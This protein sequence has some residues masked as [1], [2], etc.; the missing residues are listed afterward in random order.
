MANFGLSLSPQSGIF[1]VMYFYCFLVSDPS[2]WSQIGFPECGADVKG[3]SPINIRK[4]A[5]QN[6]FVAEEKR[7]RT[8]GDYSKNHVFDPY[9]NGR[10]SKETFIVGCRG[11]V[12]LGGLVQVSPG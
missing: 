7:F 5:V 2:L 11:V 12:Q 8:V 4:N 1:Y 10:T 6:V 9:N 3:Q